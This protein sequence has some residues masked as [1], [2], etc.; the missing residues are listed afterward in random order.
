[1]S[2]VLT[3]KLLGIFGGTFDPIHN[4]HL[5]PVIEAAKEI[6]MN[7]VIMI[8]CHIPPH[9]EQPST[10]PK[11]RLKMVEL[12]CE[13]NPL[14][15]VD[16]RELK[17]HSHSYTIETLKSLRADYPDKSLCFFM[18]SDSFSKLNSWHKWQELMDYAHIIV[19]QRD[20]RNVVL[21]PEIE[22]LLKKF[23]TKNPRELLDKNHGYIF[24]AAT[25]ELEVSSTD[26]RDKIK[27]GENWAQHVPD[28]VYDFIT[29]HRL[30]Q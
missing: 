22:G 11:L 13:H 19:C 1:M 18:G 29:T 12:A 9:K 20:S 28:S 5:N 30:Y 15:S 8:P 2:K 24:D 4:G 6:G 17:K 26:I 7:Q 14:F 23:R 10:A 27:S 21:S 3:N 16:D 25:S